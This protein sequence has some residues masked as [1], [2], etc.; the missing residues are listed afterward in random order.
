MDL[1]DKHYEG[2]DPDYKMP[3]IP[4][5]PVPFASLPQTPPEALARLEAAKAEGAK[6]QAIW[7][8]LLEIIAEKNKKQGARIEELEK[9]NKALRAELVESKSQ[10]KTATP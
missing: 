5:R 8:E 10:S 7:D 2:F 9:E 1:I 4:P 6:L 3:R